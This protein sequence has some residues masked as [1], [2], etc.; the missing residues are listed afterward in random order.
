[1]GHDATALLMQCGRDVVRLFGQSPSGHT[2]MDEHGWLGLSGE[3][4]SADFNMCFVARTADASVVEKYVREIT[5]RD[6]AA[7]MIVDEEAQHLVEAGTALGWMAVGQ[8]PVMVWESGPEP[9]ASDRFTLRIATEDDHEVVCDLVA[10]AFSL[11]PTLVKRAVP[12][13]ALA[14]EGLEAWLAEQDG[15]AVG[16]GTMIRTGD[17]VGVY[18][19]GTPERNQRQG[20]GRAVLETA[21]AHHLARG[22]KTFTLEATEAGFHLYEQLGYETVATPKVLVAGESTQFPG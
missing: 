11:D 15:E 9:K 13:S 2:Q 16:T 21:M 22:A 8:V 5:D 19:M 7:I 3:K 17:H 12:K 14:T 6:L 1:M 4:G 18:S 10:E 20:I